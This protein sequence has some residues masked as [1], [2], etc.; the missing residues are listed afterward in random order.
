[1]GLTDNLKKI[2][3]RDNDAKPILIGEF[4]TNVK[5]LKKIHSD[6]TGHDYLILRTEI[7]NVVS[8]KEGNQGVVGDEISQIYT[9]GDEKSEK[10]FRDDLFTSE[11]D[12]LLDYSSDE[13]LEASFG[14]LKDKQIYFRC[15]VYEKKDGSGKAQ[16]MAIK[17]KKSLK[18]EQLL[19]T[20]PF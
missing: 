10:K 2:T 7:I 12:G 20:I 4:V 13:A 18:P 1:M 8:K 17:N 15:W 6:K 5:E 3:P 14:N 16:S 19:P 11:L 9:V